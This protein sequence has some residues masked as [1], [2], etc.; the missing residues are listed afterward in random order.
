MDLANILPD[1]WVVNCDSRQI[2]KR[3]DIGTGKE[4]GLWEPNGVFEKVYMIENV[5]HLLIDY[6]DPQQNYSLTRFIEDFTNLFHK[7]QPEHCILIGGTGLYHHTILNKQSITKT[8]QEFQSEWNQLKQELFETPL[9][10]LQEQANNNHLTLNNSD[11]NNPRRLV[12]R[13]L[14]AKAEKSNWL[15]EIQLPVFKKV[16]ETHV[17][18]TRHK[19]ELNIKERLAKRSHQGLIKEVQSLQ[20]LGTNRL[21]ELGL[22]YR[23]TQLYLLGQLTHKDYTTALLSENL[24]L[25]KR[26]LTW[27]KKS[28]SYPIHRVED[29]LSLL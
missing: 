1:C 13:I 10:K 15:S 19:L 17:D 4:A 8:K 24:K 18:I 25:A 5:P 22:E 21:L 12:N 3:L 20:D 9:N 2:Y 28:N 6:I 29:V 14:E 27:I 23:L 11:F 26:Q 16:I 7:L